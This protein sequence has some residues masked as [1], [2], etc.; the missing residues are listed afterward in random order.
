[1]STIRRLLLPPIL[2]AIIV[3]AAPVSVSA[4]PGA[5]FGVGDSAGN[6]RLNS[7]ASA[8]I[9]W[10]ARRNGIISRLWVKTKTVTHGGAAN[11][12]YYGG[13][14]GLWQVDTYSTT[15]DGKPD[16]IH[17]VASEQFVP[18]AR[19]LA[20]DTPLGDPAGEA[21]A[22]KLNLAV[23]RG[24]EYITVFQNIDPQPSV[25]YAS[26]NFLYSASGLQGAQGRNERNP[27]APDELYGLDPRE[28]VGGMY[29]GTW[30][31]PGNNCGPFARFLPTYVQQYSD[32][33]AVGQPYYTG[34]SLAAGTPVKQHY[35]VSGDGTIAGVGAFLTA[36]DG[37]TATISVN[38]KA[39]GAVFLFGAADQFVSTAL[40]QPL[41][42]TAGSV[43]DITATPRVYGSLKALYADSVFN[44]LVGLG[45][46][47]AWS[48]TATP[49]R[50]LPLYPVYR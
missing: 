24:A 31:L 11:S 23:T 8:A 48:F 16:L 13:T 25:N 7:R 19:M 30:Y 17:L 9:R 1:M 4:A 50:T 42:V 49:T 46:G 28:L 26:L 47:F 27:A 2:L 32:G 37:F 12:S 20:D 43:V 14:T 33:V 36:T 38:G 40:P 41:S 39:G 29:N 21:I 22:V 5:P 15:P 34:T 44:R 10:V 6:I 18:A 35:L 3:L 45:A